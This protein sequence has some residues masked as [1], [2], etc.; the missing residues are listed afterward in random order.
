MSNN[1]EYL[2]TLGK[3]IKRER[4]RKGLSQTDLAIKMETDQAHIS[5]V[6]SGKRDI[7][8]TWLNRLLKILEI[9]PEELLP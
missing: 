6:E 3:N 1:K 8:V 5:R 9:N 2:I 4:E 7:H